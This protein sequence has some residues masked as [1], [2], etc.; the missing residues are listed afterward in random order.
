MVITPP[1]RAVG[2]KG[3]DV[4]VVDAVGGDHPDLAAAMVA[5]HR[6]TFPQYHY[7]ADRMVAD[8]TA[9]PVRDGLIVHQY[10]A[11]VNGVPAAYIR[12]SSNLVRRTAVI[13]YLA[14]TR[15]AR[16]VFVEGRRLADWFMRNCQRQYRVDTGTE[17]I[18]CTGEVAH[19]LL[20]PFRVY[21]W[22]VL[23]CRYTEPVHGWQWETHGLEVRDIALI[24]LPNQALSPQPDPASVVAPIA[25]SYLLDVY[26]LPTSVDWVAALVG[27]HEAAQRAQPY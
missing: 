22:Q 24:W 27:P 13:E 6:T 15:E 12:G 3:E 14:V 21:G 26:G 7:V 4:L 1:V 17:C 2:D 9:Q 23:P 25:A 8:A 18:G 11:T 16:K 5:L 20:G 10:V 19:D